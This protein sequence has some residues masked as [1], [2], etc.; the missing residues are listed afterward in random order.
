MWGLYAAYIWTADPLI[1]TLQAVRFYVPAT[2]A[3]SLLGVRPVV[4][5]PLRASLVSVT[6]GTGVRAPHEA[7]LLAVL[8]AASGVAAVRMC[9]LLAAPLSAH[10]L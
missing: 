4:N 10:Q 3:S 5:L 6:S 1:S 9:L 7:G 2:A 8:R